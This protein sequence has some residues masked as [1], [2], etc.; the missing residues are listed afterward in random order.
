MPL[1]E[2]A[3]DVAVSNSHMDVGTILLHAGA[4]S[5]VAGRIRLHLACMVGHIQV[6]REELETKVDID[7]RDARGAS[8]FIYLFIDRF[9]PKTQTQ[10]EKKEKT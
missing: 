4:T 1:G 5:G 2:T 7:S 9:L 3:F 6:V 8:K 10:I